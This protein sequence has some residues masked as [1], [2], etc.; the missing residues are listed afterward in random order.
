MSLSMPTMSSPLAAKKRV[1]SAPISPAEPVMSAITIPYPL[2]GMVRAEP[3]EAQ[4][5]GGYQSA[6]DRHHHMGF[7][8]FLESQSAKQL[9]KESRYYLRSLGIRRWVKPIT[10]PNVSSRLSTS[11]SVPRASMRCCLDCRKSAARLRSLVLKVTA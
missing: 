11:E 2:G 7:S 1:A 9:E 5:A 4:V 8:C 6:S 10:M 3:V